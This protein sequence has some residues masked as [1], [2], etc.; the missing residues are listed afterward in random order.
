LDIPFNVTMYFRSKLPSSFQT[1]LTT[2][3]HLPVSIFFAA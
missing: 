3:I 1:K 2:L